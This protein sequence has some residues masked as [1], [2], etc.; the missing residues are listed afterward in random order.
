MTV[1]AKIFSLGCAALAIAVM[2][3]LVRAQSDQA[4]LKAFA[5]HINR[6]PQQPWPG[7]GVYLGNGLILTAAH[8]AGDVAETKP[9]VVIAGQDLP[10]GLIKQG[11]LESVDLTLLSIDGTKLPVGLQ[12]RRTPLC[13]RPPYAGERV[14]VAI[15]EGTAVSKVLPRQAIPADLRGRFGTDI[16]DVATTGNSG[17]GVFDAADLCLLGIISRKISILQRPL[18]LGGPARTIDIA[19]YFVPAAEIQAFIP[20][21]VSF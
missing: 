19:K 8:V 7:Y 3:T 2:P 11:D 4:S 1:G 13:K 14:V 21:N 5:V 20:Q 9:H 18:K 15:P 12:M 10:A 6:T 16:A 17:S